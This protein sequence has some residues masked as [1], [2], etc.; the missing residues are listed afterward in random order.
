VRNIYLEYLERHHEE[1][2]SSED[3]KS[4]VVVQERFLGEMKLM[5][6]LLS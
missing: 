6:L 4:H 2:T 1:W 3:G 5:H